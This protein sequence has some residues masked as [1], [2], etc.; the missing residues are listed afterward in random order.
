MDDDFTP[1]KP[2]NKNYDFDPNASISIKGSQAPN[3]GRHNSS[4]HS[5]AR[6]SAASRMGQAIVPEHLEHSTITGEINLADFSPK[7]ARTVTK[8]AG[9]GPL[10]SKWNLKQM[11][12]FVQ[13]KIQKK[14]DPNVL[15]Q[16]V[17]YLVAPH[18][19]T[20]DTRSIRVFDDSKAKVISDCEKILTRFDEK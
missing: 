16:C 14:N 17:S 9:Y 1:D 18:N 3:T 8:T 19:M 20:Y 10:V 12:R 7:G 6:G 2:L 15:N 5:D 11:D 13:K 4:I